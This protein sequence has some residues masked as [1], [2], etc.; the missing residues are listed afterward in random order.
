MAYSYEASATR[1]LISRRIAAPA[2][3]SAT[4]SAERLPCLQFALRQRSR[5]SG[6]RGPV[7]LPPCIRQRP[8]GIPGPK[9]GVPRRVLAPHRGV[10]CW[11]L[12]G[13]T[14][15]TARR[16]SGHLR[17]PVIVWDLPGFASPSAALRLCGLLQHLPDPSRIGQRHAVGAARPT[18]WHD[19]IDAQTGW[20]PPC[21]CS[22]LILGRDSR[23]GQSDEGHRCDAR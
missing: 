20:T 10:A 6:V 13:S 3:R 4:A 18:S 16:D 22:N 8:F 15:V 14:W 9:Q 11:P 17:G 21:L 2:L 7:L 12:V 23:R 19:H 1:R 5:P